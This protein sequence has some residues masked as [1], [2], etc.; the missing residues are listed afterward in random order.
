M[1]NKPEDKKLTGAILRINLRAAD[2]ELIERAAQAGGRGEIA[3]WCRSV[4]IPAA[5]KQLAEQK[6]GDPHA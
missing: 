5:V 2:R 3:D 1:A 4:L 6:E